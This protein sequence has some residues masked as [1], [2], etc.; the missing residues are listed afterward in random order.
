V[1]SR[2]VRSTSTSPGRSAPSAAI[3]GQAGSL[4]PVSCSDFSSI[5]EAR[6]VEQAEPLW[7]VE[8]VELDDLAV[9]DGDARAVLAGAS[10]PTKSG[11]R[12]RKDLKGRTRLLSRR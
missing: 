10:P 5:V 2:E 6:Q 12:Q 8:E 9:P 7:I 4:S 1:V 3:F 11:G